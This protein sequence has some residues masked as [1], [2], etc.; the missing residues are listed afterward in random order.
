MTQRPKVTVRF[1]ALRAAFDEAVA[2][3]PHIPEAIRRASSARSPQ[4]R[5]SHLGYAADLLAGHTGYA[6]VDWAAILAG[7]RRVGDIPGIPGRIVWAIL[8]D[9]DVDTLRAAIAPGQVWIRGDLVKSDEWPT[10]RSFAMDAAER[11]IGN[12]RPPG[13]RKGSRTALRDELVTVVRA[14]PN[15]TDHEIDRQAVGSGLWEDRTGDHDTVRKRI[16]RLRK[17]AKPA[18]PDI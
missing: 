18:A 13:R 8:D 9:A 10:V 4:E 14:N 1:D 5:A 11:T 16:A 2:A 12:V 15:M 17:D 7:G 6:S 3:D